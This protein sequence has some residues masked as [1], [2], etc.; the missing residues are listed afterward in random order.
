ME[1]CMRVINSNW[2]LTLYHFGVIAA[3]CSNFGHLCFWATLWGLRDNE[4]CSSCAHWK[5]CS[6]LP[7]LVLIELFFA[8]C[9]RL[10]IGNFAPT[11]PVWPK[12]SDRRGRPTYHS[13][14]KKTRLNDLSSGIKI[15][16][17]FSSVLSQSTCFTD[18]Q[19]DTFLATRL[20]PALNAA[21]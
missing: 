9:Y 18:G 12:I 3:Y 11:W 14:S 7:I 6:G 19:T 10:K 5:V 2:H 16:T 15:W 13:S 4:H 21:R 8:K 17:D 1:A 20:C